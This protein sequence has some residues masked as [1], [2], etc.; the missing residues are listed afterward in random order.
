MTVRRIYQRSRQYLRGLLLNAKSCSDILKTPANAARIISVNVQLSS[1]RFPMEA[2]AT[3]SRQRRTTFE[4]HLIAVA[5]TPINADLCP[6]AVFLLTYLHGKWGKVLTTTP[7]DKTWFVALRRS[8]TR[9]RSKGSAVKYSRI[10]RRLE[11][12]WRVALRLPTSQGQR[13]AK[14]SISSSDNLPESS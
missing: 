2:C 7:S 8:E 3:F 12:H 13:E 9:S 5:L 10:E 4:Y 11:S 1:M 14:E 6:A